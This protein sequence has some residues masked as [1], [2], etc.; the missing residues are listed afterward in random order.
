[1]RAAGELGPALDD[2]NAELARD[3]GVTIQVRT[4][5]NTG[6]VIVGDPALG[7]ALVLGDVVNVAARLEQAAARRSPAR[8]ADLAA[9][10][11]RRAGKPSRTAK[12]QGQG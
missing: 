5:I 11:R 7:D 12:R 10:P 4:G 2:L 8:P 1:M 6:E 3:W 9:G